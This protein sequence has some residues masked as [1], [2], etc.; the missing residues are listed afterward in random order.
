MDYCLEPRVWHNEYC[1]LVFVFLCCS[2]PYSN[3]RVKMGRINIATNDYVKPSR[4]LT[5]DV[6]ENDLT[7]NYWI[8]FF[9]IILLTVIMNSKISYRDQNCYL[10]QAVTFSA[11]YKNEFWDKIGHCEMTLLR[12]SLKWPFEELQFLILLCWLYYSVQDTA[13][14]TTFTY[15]HL[16]N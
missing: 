16:A 9:L 12:A 5:A 7:L 8:R 15:Y 11:W 14:N 10:Y 1:H 4:K 3:K 2:W 13:L 6:S